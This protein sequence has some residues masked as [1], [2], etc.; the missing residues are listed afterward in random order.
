MPNANRL[1]PG[2][3]WLNVQIPAELH[4]ALDIRAATLDMAKSNLVEALLQK[5]LGKGKENAAGTSSSPPSSAEEAQG[6]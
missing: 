3:R 6:E 2:N 5:G 4:R 1:Q